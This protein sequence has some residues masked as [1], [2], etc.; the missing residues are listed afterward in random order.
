VQTTNECRNEP[1]HFGPPQ[2][3]R[4]AA[5]SVQ[6]TAPASAF[7]RRTELVDQVLGPVRCLGADPEPAVICTRLYPNDMLGQVD[8]REVEEEDEVASTQRPFAIA[9]S[10]DAK[11]VFDRTRELRQSW[12]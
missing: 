11:S 12:P 7:V 1:A 3:N 9:W 2:V 4:S 6:F 5:L 8:G 10:I